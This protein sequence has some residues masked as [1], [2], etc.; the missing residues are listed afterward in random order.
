MDWIN[1]IPALGKRA[2]QLYANGVIA[3][4]KG[5]LH[6]VVFRCLARFL[7]RNVIVTI[8]ILT[9]MQAHMSE[10][11]ISAEEMVN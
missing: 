9:L 10:Q 5:I 11:N 6:G 3:T 8:V 7:R 1:G 4:W 2:E